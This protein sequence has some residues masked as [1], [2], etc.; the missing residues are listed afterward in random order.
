MELACG[1]GEKSAKLARVPRKIRCSRELVVKERFGNAKARASGR[2]G[3]CFERSRLGEE[4]GKARRKFSVRVSSALRRKPHEQGLDSRICGSPSS[5]PEEAAPTLR[6]AKSAPRR[7]GHPK[8]FLADPERVGHPPPGVAWR[9]IRR[10]PFAEQ[11]AL[12]KGWGT[13]NRVVSGRKGWAAHPWHVVV[14]VGGLH[15]TISI[16]PPL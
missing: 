4:D 11:T 9:R 16:Q 15:H 7:V 13:Q 5:L 10:P 6:G 3:P 14:D 1:V 2:S 8:S 12:R